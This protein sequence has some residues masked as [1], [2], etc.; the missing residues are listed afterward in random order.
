MNT[1]KFTSWLEISES[2]YK[3]NLSFFKQRL[4]QQT[5][6]SVV[7]KS[8]AYGHGMAEIAQLAAK[9]GAESFCVHALDEALQ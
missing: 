7:V 8:N 4:P 6:F 3:A 2:A 1:H 5:E 9:H